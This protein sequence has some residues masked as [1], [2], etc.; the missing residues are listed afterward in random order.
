MTPLGDIHLDLPTYGCQ[1]FPKL[2]EPD[3]KINLVLE[4]FLYK[5]AHSRMSE[6][7]KTDMNLRPLSSLDCKVLCHDFQKAT[8][9]KD[10]H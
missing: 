8:H 7:E 2:N 1:N 9:F 3:F 5:R 4:Q 10:S 6:S